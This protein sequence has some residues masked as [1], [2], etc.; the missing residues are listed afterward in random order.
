MG[1]LRIA[2][3]TG[4][5]QIKAAVNSA[6]GSAQVR[7]IQIQGA[8]GGTREIQ[9][10][11]AAGEDWCPQQNDRVFVMESGVAK[12]YAVASSDLITPAVS[13]GERETYS[14]DANGQKKA[15]HK[16]KANGKHY[17][18]SE[19]GSTD[20][21]TQLQDFISA[22]DDLKTATND[23]KTAVNNLVTAL[24]TFTTGLN[25]V[26]LTAQA[27]TAAGAMPAIAASLAAVGASLSAV[28][29]NLSNVDTGMQSLLDNAP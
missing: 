17:I 23:L 15:R 19:T 7:Y 24:T 4:Q 5:Q 9:L 11:Q 2:K 26:T 20:L 27:A 12:F 14:Y 8:G 28:G 29:T 3:A 1:E 21:L 10:I 25:P 22:T 13:A 6:Q 16:L 18:Q